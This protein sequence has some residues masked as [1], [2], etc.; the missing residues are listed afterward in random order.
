MSAAALALAAITTLAPVELRG[1][2]RVDAPVEEVSIAG[3]RVGG[4]APRI[5]AWDRVRA[6]TGP[7]ATQAEAF[8]ELADL[9]WRART[10]LDRGDVLGAARLLDQLEPRLAGEPGPTPLAVFEAALEC[11]LHL[12]DQPGALRAFLEVRRLADRDDWAR[13]GLDTATGLA[14]LLAPIMT[15]AH[16][17]DALAVLDAAAPA[18]EPLDRLR[19]AFA[20]ALD[21]NPDRLPPG[22]PRSEAERLLYDFARAQAGDAAAI[23]ALEESLDPDRESD[24]AAPWRDVWTRAVLARSRL[25][26]DDPGHLRRGALA[27]LRLPALTPG[28]SPYLSG[29]AL[30]EAAR[31]LESIGEHAAAFTLRAELERVSP[32]HPAAADSAAMPPDGAVP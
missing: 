23:T 27:F 32:G 19:R 7:A 22:E 18:D 4:P 31:A 16:T 3:V 20:A 17:L 26:S 13:H 11:R 2:V 1:G 12:G 29:L 10:R 28:V 25:V 15:P 24:R 30:D 9:A 8:A 14:P 5:I 6:V 21:A